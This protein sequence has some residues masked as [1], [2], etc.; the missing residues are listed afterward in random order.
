MN[1]E[2]K[3]YGSFLPIYL[4]LDYAEQNIIDQ[5]ENIIKSPDIKMPT[6]RYDNNNRT[7]ET[8]NEIVLGLQP[9]VSFRAVTVG[10]YCCRD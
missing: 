9:A 8:I 10:V 2:H 1:K 6:Y 7:D 4:L 5:D 3:K